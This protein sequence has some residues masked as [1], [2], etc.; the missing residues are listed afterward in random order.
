MIHLDSAQI[1][2]AVRRSLESHVLP[3]LSDDFARV[4]VYAAL[5]TLAEVGDRLEHGDPC[6][7]SNRITVAGVRQLADSLRP[8]NPGFAAKLDAA[9]ANV[10]EEGPPRERARRLGESLWE[11]VSGNDDPA[12]ARL[13]ELLRQEALRTVAEDNTWMCGEAIASLT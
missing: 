12:A 6:E 4:Q 11:L 7:R 9:L 1:L 3:E 2:A 5:K 10:P 13:L 8:E